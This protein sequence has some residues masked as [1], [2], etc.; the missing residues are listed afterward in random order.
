[1]TTIIGIVAI[2]FIAFA[3]WL[4]NEWWE[5]YTWKLEQIPDNDV[6]AR[7]DSSRRMAIWRKEE[8][9]DLSDHEY[10]PFTRTMNE[11][12]REKEIK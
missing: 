7:I 6:A 4:L 10:T 5:Y 12:K 3:T 11:S 2:V 9:E 1:M 8:A